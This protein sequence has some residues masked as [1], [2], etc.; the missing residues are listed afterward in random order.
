MTDKLPP[1]LLALFAPRPPLR[2]LNPTDH[3]PEHRKTA[4]ITPVSHYLDA[5]AEYKKTD[6]YHPTESHDQHKL[7]VRLE[8]Q[9]KADWLSTEGVKQCEFYGS[10]I[11]RH[12]RN[13][14]KTCSSLSFRL[15]QVSVAVTNVL[16]R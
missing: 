6:V 2:W 1:N 16:L 12:V 15:S 3:A 11:I 14:N 4:Y 7:R 13:T 5:L 9:E 8:K 10:R